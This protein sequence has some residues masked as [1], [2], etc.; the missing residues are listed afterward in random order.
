[1]FGGLK[2]GALEWDCGGI[3]VVGF[4]EGFEESKV[5]IG[6]FRLWVY[7]WFRWLFSL[8]FVLSLQ[9]QLTFASSNDSCSATVLINL[10]IHRLVYDAGLSQ[11]QPQHLF[12]LWIH[13]E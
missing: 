4:N 6:C 10:D 5:L 3:R 13:Q 9:E 8:L 1:L 11:P 7:R 2:R 12:L